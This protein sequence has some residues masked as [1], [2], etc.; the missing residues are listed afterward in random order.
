MQCDEDSLILLKRMRLFQGMK[1][2]HSHAKAKQDSEVKEKPGSLTNALR[3]SCLVLEGCQV[4]ESFGSNL[5]HS[6]C[7]KQQQKN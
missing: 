2:E 1:N 4:R 5:Q 7:T 6:C 3:R